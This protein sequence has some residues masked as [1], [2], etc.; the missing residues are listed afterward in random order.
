MRTAVS[1][2]QHERIQLLPG[3]PA[4][5]MRHTTIRVIHIQIQLQRS[6]R[7]RQQRISSII[8]PRPLRQQIRQLLHELGPAHLHR[9]LRNH[10]P[11]Q[12][13]IRIRQHLPHYPLTE[14]PMH[15]PIGD[16]DTNRPRQRL[17]QTIPHPRLRL[18]HT[19]HTRRTNTADPIPHHGPHTRG[20]TPC[21]Q[22]RFV[23]TR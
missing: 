18:P 5:Q 17:P 8:V 3:R 7:R 11:T 9:R 23:D 6:S 14:I 21:H 12:I 10:E 4:M 22:N 15:I 1:T 2:I 13:R 20:E 16:I 19:I